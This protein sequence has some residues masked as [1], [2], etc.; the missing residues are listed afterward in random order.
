MRKILPKIA[1]IVLFWV[2]LLALVLLPVTNSPTSSDSSGEEPILLTNTAEAPIRLAL[3]NQSTEVICFVYISHLSSG[4]W[5]ESLLV[6]EAI[7]PGEIGS[8]EIP[9]GTYDLRA[10]NCFN[11]P[12]VEELAVDVVTARTW[13]IVARES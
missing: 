6:G 2:V 9:P 7:M 8:F 12:M 10:D 1:P 3:A 13:R 4:E 5:G 11:V